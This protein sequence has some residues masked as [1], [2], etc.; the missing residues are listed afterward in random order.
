MK[1]PFLEA[2]CTTKASGPVITSADELRET[3]EDLASRAINPA[4][5]AKAHPFDQAT[6]PDV[7]SSFFASGTISIGGQA[8]AIE[9]SVTMLGTEEVDGKQ[10][11]WLEL[12]VRTDPA[13]ADHREAARLLVDASEYPGRLELVRGWLA[14]DDGSTVLPL[15]TDRK[16][17][18][19]INARLQLAA[20]PHF[21]GIGVVDLMWMLFKMD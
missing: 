17:E 12:D 3:L 9:F 2:K 5:L 20:Q 19:V 1:S 14:F 6:I 8:E 4:K 13:G 16:L 11:H 21:K 7:P 15:A 10:L 18:S